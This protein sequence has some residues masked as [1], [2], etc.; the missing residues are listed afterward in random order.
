MRNP[1]ESTPSCGKREPD[2]RSGRPNNGRRQQKH[3][4]GREREYLTAAAAISLTRHIFTGR[5]ICYSA[6]RCRL[7]FVS[8]ADLLAI[9]RVFVSDIGAA[10]RSATLWLFSSI[11]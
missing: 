1:G 3:T 10:L 8:S 11:V 6:E 7:D 9:S 5:C 4:T 2:A